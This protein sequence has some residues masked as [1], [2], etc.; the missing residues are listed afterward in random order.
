MKDRNCPQCPDGSPELFCL[1]GDIL[2]DI[3]TARLLAADQ[4]SE[5]G[6]VSRADLEAIGIRAQADQPGG[7]MRLEIRSIC[8][9]HLAHIPESSLSEPILIAPIM[10]KG[11]LQ[12]LLIDGAH[13]AAIQIRRGSERVPAIMLTLEQSRRAC[14][15]NAH[16]VFSDADGQPI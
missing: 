5:M 8:E 16:L 11:Q 6:Y 3:R 4:S 2:W 7:S 14:I 1:L 10:F 9:D 13:R 15:N 12:H